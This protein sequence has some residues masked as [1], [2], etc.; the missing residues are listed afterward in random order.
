MSPSTAGDQGSTPTVANPTPIEGTILIDWGCPSDGAG[1]YGGV[2]F[3][4]AIDVKVGWSGEIEYANVRGK[5]MWWF[6]AED[7]Y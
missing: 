7:A 1:V 6:A 5:R 4:S 3:D 2:S